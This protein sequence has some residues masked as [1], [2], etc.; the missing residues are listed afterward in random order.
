M[1]DEVD[2]TRRTL[3]ANERT[4]LAWWRGALTALAVALGAG[5]LVP[6]LT[7]AT[8]WPFAILGVGFGLLAVAFVVYGSYRHRAVEAAL[9]RGGFAPLDRRVVI[10]LG[11]FGVVL[12]LL[13]ILAVL[14]EV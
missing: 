5:A 8:R 9:Q 4:L 11:G 10:A 3:L 2:A 13:T 14:L 6:K 1:E 7:D 12:A